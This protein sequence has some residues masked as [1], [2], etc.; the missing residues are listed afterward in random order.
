MSEGEERNI[1]VKEA[2][3]CHQVLPHERE[4]EVG[5]HD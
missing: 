1:H 3:H 2:S 5:E 4:D